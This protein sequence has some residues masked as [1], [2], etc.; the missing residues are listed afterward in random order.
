MRKQ[1]LIALLIPMVCAAVPAAA[2]IV[3]EV[4]AT[5]DREVILRSDL[6]IMLMPIMRDIAGGELS[7]EDQQDALQQALDQAIEQKILYREAL[8]SGVEIDEDAVEERFN[9]IRGSYESPEA[10]R[11][12]IEST[13]ETVSEFRDRVR[14]Q[15]IILGFAQFMRRQFAEEAVISEDMTQEYYRENQGEFAQPTRI[16][17]RRIFI[18]AGSDAE[19]R[20]RA[21]AKLESLLDEIALGAD[22]AE[23]AKVHSEGPDAEDGGLV[24]WVAPGDLVPALDNALFAL[25]QGETSGVLETDFGFQVLLAEE[26]EEAG[27]ASLEQARKDIEPILREEYALERFRAW[28]DE[29]RKRSRVRV[30]I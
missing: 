29:L 24:G 7:A 3:D 9:E 21:R 20:A 1:S 22:F 10:F 25:Q 12:A 6:E 5:V 16:L 14:Q 2:V 26:R 15:M 28:V 18:S 4:V 8:L 27:E 17:T 23:L 30:L 11:E 13:G 19:E